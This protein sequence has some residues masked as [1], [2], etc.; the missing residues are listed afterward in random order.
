MYL[1]PCSS[2]DSSKTKSNNTCNREMDCAKYRDSRAPDSNNM[3]DKR[4]SSARGEPLRAADESHDG[5]DGGGGGDD[6]DGE[7]VILRERERERERESREHIWGGPHLADTL[8]ISPHT[9]ST[10]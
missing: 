2:V 4:R 6:D 8:T 1:R 5:D 3:T 7:D 10:P 9:H